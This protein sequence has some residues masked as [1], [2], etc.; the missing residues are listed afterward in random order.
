MFT[1]ICQLLYLLE[2]APRYSINFRVSNTAL[3]IQGRRQF[4]KENKGKRKGEVG[5][6]LL[7]NF[8]ALMTELH[9]TRIVKRELNGRA[10]KQSLSTKEHRVRWK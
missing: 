2:E 10:V 3:I 9:I 8:T 6:V 4:K 5:L 1:V 7:A